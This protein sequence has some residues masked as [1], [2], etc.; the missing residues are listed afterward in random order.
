MMMMTLMIDDDNNSGDVAAVA[1]H[2][3]GDSFV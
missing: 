3:S 1:K 2:F